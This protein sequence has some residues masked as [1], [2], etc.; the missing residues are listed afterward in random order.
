MNLET[1]RMLGGIGAI[2]MFIMPF[3]GAYTGILGL[4]GLIMVL[5]AM[6]GL[7]DNYSEQGIFNNALYGVIAA[8]VG[9]VISAAVIFVA[10]FDMFAALG[11]AIAQ[12][13]DWQMLQQ[14]DWSALMST[15][16]LTT[17]LIYIVASLVVLFVFIIITAIFLRKSLNLISAKSGVGLFGTTG[18]LVLIGAI[19]TIIAIG[20]LLIWIALILLAVAFFSIRPTAAQPA[21]APPPQ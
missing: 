9:G 21:P 1:S 8:I 13:T 17:F 14:L 7:A 3:L 5:I 11:I 15:E 2:L 20:L 4:I 6:K 10:A 16:I 18:L 19:L 12:W